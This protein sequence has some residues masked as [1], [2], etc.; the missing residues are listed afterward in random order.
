MLVLDNDDIK[1]NA[2]LNNIIFVILDFS[3]AAN[4]TKKTNALIIPK[5]F[6]LG[7]SP[8]ISTN[9]PAA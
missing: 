1:I 4:P 5:L 9:L 6:L 3:R 2:M 7:Y 8:L